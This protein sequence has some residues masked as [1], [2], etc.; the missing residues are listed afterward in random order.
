MKYSIKDFLPLIVIFAIII[1]F[2]VVRQWLFGAW[3]WMD[4]MNDFMGAFFIVFGCFKLVNLNGFVEAYRI[5]DVVAQKI[6]LYAY[7]YPFIEVT[8]GICYL[9][10]L[11][12]ITT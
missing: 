6:S 12:P 2:T 9:L 1:S 3:N 8:L 10:R 5:Y 11:F 4:A 7:I